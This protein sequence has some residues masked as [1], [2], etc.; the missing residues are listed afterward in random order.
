MNKIYPV[1]LCGGVGSRLWP[2]SRSNS[3]K[4]FQQVD[5]TDVHSFFQATVKRHRGDLFHDP[6]VSVSTKYLPTVVQQLADMNIN[7]S[8]I[9]EP[10]SRNTGPAVLASAFHLNET[11]PSAVMAVLPSDH[12][13]QGDFNELLAR[14]IPAAKAGRIALFGIEPGYPETGYGYIVDGGDHPDHP[15]AQEV[16]HFVEKPP[17]EKAE[18]LIAG[19]NAYWASGISLFRADVIISEYEKIDPQTYRAVKTAFAKRKTQRTH[20][21]LCGENFARA[22]SGPTEAVIFEKTDQAVLAPTRVDWND[23]G[24]WNA[25]HTINEKDQNGNVLSGDVICVETSN[26]YVRGS[27]SKLIATVGVDNLV[28]VDTDDALL[29]TTRD[30]CQKVKSVISTLQDQGRQEVVDHTIQ[31]TSWGQFVRMENG[32]AYRL[33]MLKLDPNA[34]ISFDGDMEMHRLFTA[35]EGEALFKSGSVVKRLLPGEVAELRVGE[36]G[37]LRNRGDG[38]LTILEV[39][40]DRVSE[41]ALAEKASSTSKELRGEGVA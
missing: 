16:S 27:S 6:V 22:N 24:A 14:M 7:A 12:V 9:A 17:L 5:P 30:N 20:Q 36:S 37:S 21:T 35:S 32:E 15:E 34:V 11:D 41:P 4:Q 39:Q 2:L 29:I 1:V 23:V 19:K 3:P 8:I 40:Y 10:V 13:I 25:F 18:E 31:R 26:S 28:V 33:N 38:I